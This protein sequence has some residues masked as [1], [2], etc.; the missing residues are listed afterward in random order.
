MANVNVVGE[1]WTWVGKPITV[2][3]GGKE[4]RMERITFR[5]VGSVVDDYEE[6]WE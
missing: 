4:V 5:K 3:L 6:E 2:T 1:S